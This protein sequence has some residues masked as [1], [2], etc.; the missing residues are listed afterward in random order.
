MK[1][2]YTDVSDTQKSLVVEI[3]SDVVEHEIERVAR[4]YAR[5]AKLPGFRP[6]KIPPNV[7]RRKF[8][9]QILHDV[10]HD[11]IPRAV[12][13]ALRE[14]GVEPVDT[15]NVRDMS[16][17]EGQPLKFTAQIETAPPVDPGDLAAITLRR[18]PVMV[19]DEDVDRTIERLRSAHA[20]FEPVE[21]RG[22]EA[23]EAVV[24]NMTRRKL[25]AE[26]EEPVPPETLENVSVE[27]G[28]AGNPPGFD[29][30]IVGLPPG[31]SKTF[32]V[33]FPAEYPVESLAGASV[34]Y[35]VTVVGVRRKVLPAVDDEFSK[36]MGYTSLEELRSTVR[37]RLQREAKRNQ[38]REVRQ[39]LLRQLARRV[40][41]AAP[42]GL[43]ARE[44]ERRIEEFV[45]QLVEQ[46]VDPRQVKV[47]WDEMRKGQREAAEE[48]VKCAL[49]LDEIA[50]REALRVEASE[51]DT[52]IARFAERSKTA[53]DTVRDR[54][55]KEGA[56]G[57]IYTGLRREKAIDYALGRA[58]I[59]DI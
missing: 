27:L 8:R 7:V 19:S 40:T 22:A 49:V 10:A 41:A 51:I 13:D 35:A 50:R 54:L 55:T 37:E 30:E 23:G 52:E 33:A 43:L 2:D 38:D 12:D 21:G 18:T 39:D 29:A 31:E 26:G 48:T 15:P 3:P 1:V 32:T 45:H 16:I 17:D 24:L 36:D 59:V 58:T 20:R 14:R 53:P 25:A 11:L 4:D 28:D 34:E 46:G 42:E 56:I 6:G 5:Q 9:A 47:D 44:V 57:R